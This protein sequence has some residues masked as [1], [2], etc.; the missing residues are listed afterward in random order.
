M[1]RSKCSPTT[2]SPSDAPSGRVEVFVG[3]VRLDL[4]GP[5]RRSRDQLEGPAEDRRQ[6]AEPQ[7][8]VAAKPEVDAS[9]PNHLGIELGDLLEQ[10]RAAG[11]GPDQ[12]RPNLR[13]LD[14]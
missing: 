4:D 2:T 3:H 13:G 5:A 6:L 9:G 14:L 12:G 1:C 11:P 8:P 10:P 7:G